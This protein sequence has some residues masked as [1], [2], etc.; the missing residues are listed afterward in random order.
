M[1]INVVRRSNIGNPILARMMQATG[2]QG[3]SDARSLMLGGLSADNIVR[4][5][6]QVAGTQRPQVQPKPTQPRPQTGSPNGGNKPQGQPANG[7]SANLVQSLIN[8]G[9]SGNNVGTASVP[10]GDGDSR[11][12][13]MVAGVAKSRG[14]GALQSMLAA[15][16][17][18]APTGALAKVG[19]G[20]MLSPVSLAKSIAD[21]ISRNYTDRTVMENLATPI[22]E[23]LGVTGDVPGF[24]TNPWG[25]FGVPAS[26]RDGDKAY[27]AGFTDA[28]GNPTGSQA[29]QAEMNADSPNNV[30]GMTVPGNPQLAEH[31]AEAQ[32]QA[33]VE[34]QAAAALAAIV[35]QATRTAAANSAANGGQATNSQTSAAAMSNPNNTQSPAQFG[36]AAN[37]GSG[38][39]R[40]NNSQTSASAMS[41]SNN[42]NSPAGF[43]GHSGYGR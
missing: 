43:G 42:T 9:S 17:Q 8:K 6:T 23:M 40:G 35:A 10:S 24:H 39:G 31:V 13:Q 3:G 38:G 16:L 18:G 36:G 1:A 29:T 19:L 12:G 27:S 7:G 2:A 33:R 21:A 4:A 34:A 11:A 25:A 30:F 26:L 32:A 41:N 20:A 5:L 15:G 28:D 14:L 22:A 37:N